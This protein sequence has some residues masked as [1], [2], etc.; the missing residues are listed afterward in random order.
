MKYTLADRIERK[1]MSSLRA[2]LS[3]HS[4]HKFSGNGD[5][6]IGFSHSYGRF[7][8]FEN[9]DHARDWVGLHGNLTVCEYDGTMTSE[10][11]RGDV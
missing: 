3:M 4:E 1:E 7:Y 6:F 11:I 9:M 5:A 10:T 2:A 8:C